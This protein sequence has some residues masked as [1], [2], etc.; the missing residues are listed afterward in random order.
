MVHQAL[1]T[2]PWHL[3]VPSLTDLEQLVRV[4]GQFLPEVHSFL[5][6]LFVRCSLSSLMVQWKT[7]PASSNR[8]LSCLLHLFVRLAGEP[9]AQQNPMMKRILDEACFYP[10]HLVD[11]NVYDQVLNWY[12]STSDPL[13]VLQPYLERQDNASSSNDPLVFR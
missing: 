11:A 1:E 5:V 2:L 6:S 4:T 8:L 9:T 12:I 7:Q 10:W 3:F 13:F